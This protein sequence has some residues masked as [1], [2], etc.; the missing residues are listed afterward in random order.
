M[1]RLGPPKQGYCRPIIACMAHYEDKM[2][3][4]ARCKFLKEKTGISISDDASVKAWASFPPSQ[5][6]VTAFFTKASPLQNDFTT[7][8]SVD[9][10]AFNCVEQFPIKQKA[11]FLNETETATKIMSEKD[12]VRQKALGKTIKNYQDKEWKS[13]VTD[14]IRI[15][16]SAK[17]KQKKPLRDS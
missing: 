14:I 1:H 12:P 5:N 15:G 2:M 7:N 8:F 11:I 16:L 13:A 6:G 9:N 4:F 17:F 10:E 3:L